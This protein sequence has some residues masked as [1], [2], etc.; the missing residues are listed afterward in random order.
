MYDIVGD[1]HGY[2]DELELLLAKLGYQKKNGIWQ[3]SERT[4][5]SVGDLI[6]R[7]PQQKR[8]VDIIRA[9]TANGFAKVIMGNH[10][11]NAV[12]YYVRDENGEP[13]RAH[14]L[15]NRQQHLAFL[16]EAE[17]IPSWYH[18]T[19]SWFKR[20]PVLLDLPE[21]RV[22]HA[23]W[24][25][26]SV[27][28]LKD[29]CTDDFTLK[30]PYFKQANDS[31]HP[32]YHALEVLMKGWELSLPEGVSFN[33][34][35]GHKRDKIRTRWW[36][37]QDG[38]YQDLAIGVPD[39][40]ILPN[41]RVP[42]SQMPGYDNIKPLFIGHY[43][44]HESP[45][46]VSAHIACVDYSVAEQGALV[47]YR[48][49]GNSFDDADFI[50]VPTRPDGH[51]STVQLNAAFYH[52]DPMHTCCVE[53]NCT[54]EYQRIAEHSRLLLDNKVALYDA[55]YQALMSAFDEEWVE[56]KH[57]IAVMSQLASS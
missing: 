14:S 29:Y 43:W 41:E 40:S 15:K 39:V 20:L 24:H 49:S 44:L 54:D 17:A 13:L 4:L 12:A 11:F 25:P 51:F 18:E 1:I 42:S 46:A 31:A 5:I 19:I 8:A 47:A 28:V 36:L 27:Y 30:S 34:K 2:A 38:N 23:C 22:V 26:A 10:E 50:S 37:E 35:D 7:G 53:N 45:E 3:H 6:D 52:A 16:N 48:F 32:L 56:E 57:V 21:L 9:M 33:D 55:I